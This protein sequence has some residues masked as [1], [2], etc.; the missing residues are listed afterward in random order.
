MRNSLTVQ[1]NSSHLM[2][3]DGNVTVQGTS[4]GS[5][6]MVIGE[7]L[8]SYTGLSVDN[9]SNGGLTIDGSVTANEQ[10][11]TAAAVINITNTVTNGSDPGLRPTGTLTIGNSVDV[12]AQTTGQGFATNSLMEYSPGGIVVG[13]AIIMNGDDL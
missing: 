5:P 8:R 12:S 6:L 9:E 11:S 7:S 2:T 13:N 4:S 10:S 1:N 3:I